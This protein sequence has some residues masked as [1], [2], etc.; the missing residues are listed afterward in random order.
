MKSEINGRCVGKTAEALRA[1]LCHKLWMLEGCKTVPCF[2]LSSN[3]IGM[4]ER[5]TDDDIYSDNSF[6]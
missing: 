5:Q 1:Y 2:S 4:A 3:A 6:Q